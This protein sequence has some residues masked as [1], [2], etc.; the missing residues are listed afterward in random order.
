VKKIG[1][2]SAKLKFA[3]AAKHLKS[4][5]RCI[6]KYSASR[7]YTI[8]KTKSKKTVKVVVLRQ[9]PPQIAILAGEMLYQ[10]RSALD[11]L[12]FD[13]VKSNWGNAPLPIRW[14]KRCEFPL[15]VEVPTKGEPPVPYDTPLPK[16]VLAKNLPGISQQAFAFIEAV[17]PHYG[18]GAINNALRY[19]AQLSNIDKHRYLNVVVARVLK[20]DT[21]RFASGLRT[22]GFEAFNHGT[23]LPAFTTGWTESDRAV[24]VNRRFHMRVCFGESEV[25]GEAT[26]LAVDRLLQLILEQ[27]QTVIIPA[28]EE[29]L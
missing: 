25:L 20:K 9:P 8:A 2:V 6:A 1:L 3:R 19:L 14:D 23:E 17:Q 26:A 28:F 4:I 18:T 29:L 16:S 12:A 22:T 24:Y 7:P 10:I 27:I 11:H 21:V 15:F 13:L 5:Q